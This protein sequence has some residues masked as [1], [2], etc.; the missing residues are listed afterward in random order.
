MVKDK[1]QIYLITNNREVELKKTFEQIFAN[2]SPIKDFDITI[3]NN[4]STDGTDDLISKYQKDF[5]NL[6]HV[7]N[8]IN[9]GGNAN[10]CRAYETAAI[11][12]KEYAWI[13]CDDDLYNFDNWAEVEKNINEGKDIICVSDYGFPNKSYKT[14][15][16]YQFLQL[17]FVPSCIFKTSNVDARIIFNMYEAIYTMFPQLVLAADIINAN[18]QIAVLSNPIVHNGTFFDSKIVNRSFNRGFKKEIIIERRKVRNWMLGFSNAITLLDDT[19]IAKDCIEFSVTCRD[20]YGC[21]QNFYNDLCY[22]YLNKNNF[23]YFYEIYKYL[24][25]KRKFGFWCHFLVKDISGISYLYGR[26][27]NLLIVLR[28]RLHNLLQEI[29]SGK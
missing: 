23:N 10:I 24:R 19:E 12:G 25:F 14:N 20:I 7:R 11:C 16:A 26:T 1:L 18:K 27:K 29:K 2:N 13:L 17:A 6:K 21:W 4:A 5:P 3:I 22:K 9:I 15:K 8:P 28:I